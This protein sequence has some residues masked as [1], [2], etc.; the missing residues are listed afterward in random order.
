MTGYRRF[1]RRFGRAL[2]YGLLGAWSAFTILTLAY[3]ILGAFKTQRELLLRPWSWPDTF[4]WENFEEAWTVA[5]LGG[6]FVNS[7]IVVTAA[8]FLILAISAPAA[9]VLS[10]GIFRGRGAL[11]GYLLL[12]MGIPLPLLYIPLFSLFSQLGLT[13]SLPGL[14]V[15]FVATSLPFTIYLLTGFFSGVPSAIGDA[16]TMDGCGDWQKFAHIYLPLSRSGMITAAIFNAVWLWNEYQLTLILITEQQDR[17]LPLGLFA[18]Q[19]ATQYSGN[20]TEFYAGVTIVVIP[21]L[22][23]FLIL[24]ERMIAGMTAGAVK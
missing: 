10:R 9:Y 20:W 22:I 13:N 14:I 1:H 5:N 17:T 11:T 12:G 2:T 3:V 8:V 6:Y 4:G 24:S 16:A 21:T 18:L 23:A 7:V 19:T 15:A